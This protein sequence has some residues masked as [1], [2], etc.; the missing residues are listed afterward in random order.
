MN[1]ISPIGF[2]KLSQSSNSTKI[3]DVRDYSE[4]DEYHINT[5]TNVPLHTLCEKPHLY[6]NTNYKYYLICKN[7]SKSKIATKYLTDIGYNV[8]NVIGGL[9]SMI[10]TNLVTY[11]Y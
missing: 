2:F 9:N 4:F 1:E 6:L 3:I 5:S 10:E 11:F 7:G 8:V